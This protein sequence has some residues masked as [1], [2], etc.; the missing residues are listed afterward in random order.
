VRIAHRTSRGAATMDE[1]APWPHLLP[2]SF[3]SAR[4]SGLDSSAMSWYCIIRQ[5]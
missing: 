4:R 5:P 1:G 2:T 3:G